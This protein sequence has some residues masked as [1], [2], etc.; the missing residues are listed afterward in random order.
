MCLLDTL[1]KQTQHTQQVSITD[2][3]SSATY[4]SQG[5]V[6]RQEEREAQNRVKHDVTDD[7]IS[8]D[9]TKKAREGDR[10]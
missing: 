7:M 4:L 5:H 3:T 10:L 6:D 9:L 8:A 2:G 1:S